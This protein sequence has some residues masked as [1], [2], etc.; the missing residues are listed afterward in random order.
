MKSR[1][2]QLQDRKVA[3]VEE[4]KAMNA[5][6]ATEDRNAFN[7]DET[8]SFALLEQEISDVDSGLSVEEKI[9]KHQKSLAERP[10]ATQLANE[11]NW[12]DTDQ[13]LAIKYPAQVSRS[14]NL[15]HFKGEGK[16]SR[17]WN[18]AA[19]MSGQFYLASVWKSPRSIQWCHEHGLGLQGYEYQQGSQYLAQSE[20]SNTSGAILVPDVLSDLIID[21]KEKRGV[22]A[23]FAN[24]W[25]MT[26]DNMTIPRRLSGLTAYFVSDGVATTESQLGWDGVTLNAKELAVLARYPNTL[27]EDAIINMADKLTGEIAYAIA[28]KEDQ[29]G[30]VG[31]GAQ[32]YGGIQGLSVLMDDVNHGNSITTNGTTNGGQVVAAVG[33]TS[34]GAT[35]LT[36]YERMVGLLPQYAA[37]NAKWYFSR[38]GFAAGPQRLIDAAGGNTNA[39]LATGG[40]GNQTPGNAM[41]TFLGYPVV[42]V[43]VLNSTL[44]AQASTVV[45]FFGDLSLASSY[46]ARR[47]IG[48]DSSKDRYFEFRQ[49][50]IMGVERFDI[51]NHDLGNTTTAG[52]IVSLK[53]SAT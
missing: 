35:V 29:C 28:D 47:E 41:P 2:K 7:E 14:Y 42:I 46:G 17:E 16:T 30:F 37:P 6:L 25:P 12:S 22:F 20:N 45:A 50:A 44:S 5:L 21:L 1:L 34:Y 18:E 10:D 26:S 43:Q 27:N 32:S 23:Q 4:M 33:G 13:K 31:T 53:T 11:K 15:S 38:A 49:I 3:V 39:T 48:I 40:P 8:K 9:L 19:Y 52:P 24:R 36:D 51:V